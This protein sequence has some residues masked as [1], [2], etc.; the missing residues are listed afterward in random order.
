MQQGLQLG[1][2]EA[3]DTSPDRSGTGAEQ[4]RTGD[5]QP[6][7]PVAAAPWGESEEWF[8]AGNATEGPE[9]A[10]SETPLHVGLPE[11]CCHGSCACAAA[12]P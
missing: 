7:S 1:G 4:A 6:Y 8:E 11:C 10:Q 2:L 12:A 9:A 3:G 5:S